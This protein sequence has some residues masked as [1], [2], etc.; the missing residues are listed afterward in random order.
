M[1][2]IIDGGMGTML[3]AAE[4]TAQECPELWNLEQPA[5]ITAIHRAYI[6]AGADIIETNS[7]G[8][9]YIK[10]REFQ[11]EHRH[12]EINSA[13]AQNAR[14]A[15]TGN[16]L[17]AGSI[18]PTGKMLCPLGELSFDDAYDCFARQIS[19]LDTAGV[20]LFIIETMIDIQEARAALIAAKSVTNKPV[21]CQ[22]SFAANGRTMSGTDAGTAAIVLDKLGADVIGANCST[23]PEEML[24]IVR[25]LR[26]HTNKPISILPNAGLPTVQNGTTVFPMQP[27]EFADWA[28]KLIQ[29]GASYIGG[30][31]GTAPAHIAAVASRLSSRDELS[32]YQVAPRVPASPLQLCSRS[33]TITVAPENAPLVIGE[34]INPTNRKLLAAELRA[35]LLTTVINDAQA[36]KNQ[37]AAVLDVNVGISGIDQ[38]KTMERIVCQLSSLVDTPLA[39]DTTDAAVLEVG[40]KN[41]PGRAL[42]N[43]V[44]LEHNRLL[45]FLT[46]AKKY[47]AAVLVLPV[48]D[49]GLPETALARLE[50]AKKIIAAG[51][52]LGLAADDF[53]LDPLALSAAADATAC[54]VTLQTIRLYCSELQLPV[55]MGLSNASYGLPERPSFNAAFL[56]A[57]LGAGLTMPIL[58]PLD[59]TMQQALTQARLICGQPGSAIEY[60]EATKKLSSKN[61][62][63]SSRGAPVCAPGLSGCSASGLSPATELATLAQAV[64]D[65]NKELAAQTAKSALQDYSL[66]EISE[67]GIAA[68]IVRAGDE[69][70]AGLLFL[71]QI[72]LSA[73]AAKAAFDAIKSD[74]PLQPLGKV[75]LGTVYG[76][77]HDLGKNIVAALLANSSFEVVDL[78]KNVSP[79]AFLEAAL[80]HHPDIIGFSSLM[81]T[82]MVEIQPTIELLRAHG[83]TA[84]FII[85][86]AV[87]TPEYAKECGADAFACDAVAAI[88]VCKRLLG[89]SHELV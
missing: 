25:T 30:C 26:T 80:L 37:L 56:L 77:I 27:E 52:T 17:V 88:A 68:G 71:P 76:D 38:A 82:T 50:V 72:L 7:F 47:G 8:A 45:P 85:G 69:Y 75:L 78:G 63:S 21:F 20:D 89:G 29:A 32:S 6:A 53:I 84:K 42:I 74:T 86:G 22:L 4:I 34:R 73:E 61:E 9:N 70:N 36:Q 87:T 46:L 62:L 54:A 35:G 16:Q 48:T 5:R 44:S 1:L 59:E 58:N 11:L 66:L 18:G 41:F 24:A 81:T 23:G 39:I 19:V 12:D 10:L 57:A 51:K 33:K 65:G 40:L 28:V 64:Y 31:C 55:T 14:A 60:I 2:K 67:Q 49:N 13:A 15:I 3:Q 79:Q 43:S 83:C